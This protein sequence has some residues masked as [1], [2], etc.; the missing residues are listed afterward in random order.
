MNETTKAVVFQIENEEYALPIENVISIEKL[1]E[2]T[3][4]PHLPSY[5]KGIV[6]VRDELIPVL[7]LEDILYHRALSLNDSSRL[8]VLQA[9]EFSYGALV[10]EAKEIIDIPSD[11]LK[12]VSF[13]ASP[14]TAYL[15]G[16]ANLN[17]R[18]I[19][20]LNPALLADSIEGVNQVKEYMQSRQ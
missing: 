15:A 12:Q 4:I 18:L 7:D 16:I 3:P 5:V 13:L 20:V 14:K 8:I 6:E 1:E 11:N 19:T 2:V 17:H 10:G 9:G